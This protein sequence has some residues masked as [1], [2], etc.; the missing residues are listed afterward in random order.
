MI[1]IKSAVKRTYSP[2][3]NLFLP[4]VA[5]LAGTIACTRADVPPPAAIGS[6]GLPSPTV[7]ATMLTQEPTKRATLADVLPLPSETPSLD[8]PEPIV[9]PTFPA[10]PTTVLN[11]EPEIVLYEAEPGDTVRTLAIRFGVIPEEVT[12]PDPL[13][14]GGGM[15]DPGQLLLIP[16]RLT[17]IGPEERLIPDSELIF[18]PHATDFDV[19]EFSANQG[20]YLNSYREIVGSIW[21]TGAEV[22]EI[23]ARNN[24]VNPRLLL[25]LLEYQA[26]WVT[27]STPASGDAFTYPMG[28]VDRQHMG[29]HRQLTWLANELGNGY[30]GWRAGVVTDLRFRGGSSTRLAPTLNAATVGLHYYFSLDR[31]RSSWEVAITEGAFMETYSSLFGDPWSYEYLIYELGVEQPAL[32]LPFLPGRI[33]AFTGG[34]HGAWERESAWAAL[35]FAPAASES[36]CVLSGEWVVASAPG[37]VIRSENGTVVI[38]LDGDGRENSGWALLYLHVDKDGRVAE[39][40][41]VEEGDRLGHPSCEGGTATGTHVHIARKYNGEWILADGPLPFT[42]S[43][44]VARAG[45]RPYKGALVK[46]GEEVLACSCASQETLIVR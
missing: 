46:D 21:R 8:R 7:A 39:G 15:I 13:P 30:Y 2:Y 9:S 18:S 20:G 33:W 4:I 34:P 44:W 3:F 42:L 41:F 5:L 16:S 45:L 36:G 35:D 31:S 29:L 17:E 6:G 28:H 38:D 32:I 14:T 10:T 22:V 26:G 27:D 12:S 19:V 25:A 37:Q 23:V 40:E 24:S 11:E 43:G 1:S